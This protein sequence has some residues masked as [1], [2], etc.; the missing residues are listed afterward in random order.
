MIARV[1]VSNKKQRHPEPIS[2]VFAYSM[3][4]TSIP[5]NYSSYL[6]LSS[7]SILYSSPSNSLYTLIPMPKSQDYGFA[8][9][10]IT[11]LSCSLKF[12]ISVVL[13]RSKQLFSWACKFCDPNKTSDSE[14]SSL[15]WN[16]NYDWLEY[17]LVSLMFVI[18]LVFLTGFIF[19]TKFNTKNRI[20]GYGQNFSTSRPAYRQPFPNS[21]FTI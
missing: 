4:L 17:I 6:A 13:D 2:N 19:F 5:S 10:S 16:R 7:R 21:I 20:P 8:I 12:L 11:L 18:F 3:L 15:Y 1:E 9:F 14:M